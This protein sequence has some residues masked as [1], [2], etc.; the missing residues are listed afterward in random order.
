[1]PQVAPGV[2]RRIASAMGAAGTTSAETAAVD[3]LLDTD[4]GVVEA[5]ARSLLAGIPT[6]QEG[7]RK[8]LA[9]HLLQ[10][11]SNKHGRLSLASETAV[12]RLLAALDD[13][14]APGPLWERTLPPYAMEVR[15]A[16]LQALGKWADAPTKDQLRRLLT[17]AA[18]ANFR[19]AAPAL[20]ILQ[21]LPVTDRSAGDWLPLLDAPDV[22]VRRVALEKIGGRDTAAVAAALVKQLD[23]PDRE[24]REQAV[25]R[26]TTLSHGRQALTQ[27]LVNAPSPDKAWML[28]QA[29]LPFVK[30][31]PLTARNELFETACQA[32]EARDRRA[33]AYLSLLREA[34]PA[35]TRDQLEQRALARRKRKDYV[36]A[37]IYLRYLARDP[38]CGLGIRLEL[39]AAGL[40]ESNH[41]LTAEARANDPGLQQFARLVLAQPAEVMEYLQKAKWLD[42]EDL[43]YL[44]F[45]FAEKNGPEKKFGGQVLNLVIKRSPRTKAAQNAKSKLRSAGLS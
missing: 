9:D 1:M 18:D 19:I 33:D 31:Y 12:V 4:P 8:G 20:L 30:N 27:A 16:A 10:L 42:A 39:A 35:E 28:A 6:L 43:L 2:R 14:R 11:L 17:C 37:L 25:S 15:A 7:H 45:H 13:Q 36:N 29:Q 34:S 21:G 3:A 40:K 38:A 32:L 22:A 23:H 26:L 44:G 5:T 41:D 24:L